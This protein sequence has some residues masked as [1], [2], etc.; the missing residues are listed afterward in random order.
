MRLLTTAIVLVVVLCVPFVIWGDAFMAKFSGESVIAWIRGWGAWGWLAV[1]GLLMSDLFLPIPA[2]PV[3]SAAGYLYG[4]LVG[5]LMSAAGSF[6]AGLAGYALCRALGRGFA[7][8]LV[9]EKELERHGT[10]FQRSGPWIVAA[11]RWLPLLP[12]VVSCLAGLTRMPLRVFALALACGSVPLGFVYAAIGAAGQDNPKLA[13]ALNII[14]PPVLWLALH[15]VLR[16]RNRE[17]AAE[18][19]GG[20]G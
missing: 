4:P 13:V 14:V 17:R 9:G 16:R 15:L 2:T 19:Q 10:L 5:G 1:F 20:G 12:E 7:V 6:A 18:S 8:R 11:S 3:M